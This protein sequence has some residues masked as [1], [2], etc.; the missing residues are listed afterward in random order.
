MHTPFCQ[1]AGEHLADENSD[2]LGSVG[3]DLSGLR[4]SST[5][6]HV[7]DELRVAIAQDTDVDASLRGPLHASE[8]IAIDKLMMRTN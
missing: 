4:G 7:R 6:Q 5:R 3:D 1:A 2:E 8:H